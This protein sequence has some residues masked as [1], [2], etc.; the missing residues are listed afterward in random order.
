MTSKVYY[1]IFINILFVL[2]ALIIIGSWTGKIRFGLG[3][4]DLV[5]VGIMVLFSLI[6][7]VY[8]IYNILSKGL[9]YKLSISNVT[10][11]TLYLCFLFFIILQMTWFRGAES[12]WD[13]KIFF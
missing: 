6:V 10:V 5:Y 3:M 4:G 9:K 12:K 2:N 1:H 13:G 8:Y 7:L 11:L